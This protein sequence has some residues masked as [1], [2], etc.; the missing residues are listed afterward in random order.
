MYQKRKAIDTE[1]KDLLRIMCNSLKFV[2]DTSDLKKMLSQSQSTVEKLLGLI[3]QS[4]QFIR[5]NISTSAIG[6]SEA[7]SVEAGL[8]WTIG[9]VWKTE[10]NVKKLEN[11]KKQL[12]SL[13]C[14]LHG[15]AIGSLA[16]RSD[17][18]RNK[19]MHFFINWCL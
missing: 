15:D 6:E 2:E 19:G 5:E 11:Y 10:E 18:A 3:H 7:I 13:R 12:D 8:T 16:R 4:S 17:I 9:E 14:D 1:I